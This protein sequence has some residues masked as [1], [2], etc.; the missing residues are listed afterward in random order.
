LYYRDTQLNTPKD[1]YYQPNQN[2][3]NYKSSSLISDFGFNVSEKDGIISAIEVDG[4]ADKA[5]LMLK[6]KVIS[7]DDGAFNL[8]NKDFLVKRF[9]DYQSDK[10]NVNVRIERDGKTIDYQLNK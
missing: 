7:I 4:I 8:E 5:G 3:N 10:Q 9:I 1:L 2:F 6:D